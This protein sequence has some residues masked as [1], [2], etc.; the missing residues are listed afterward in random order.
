[1]SFLFYLFYLTKPD[2]VYLHR[3]GPRLAWFHAVTCPQILRAC[4]LTGSAVP[5][6]E[7]PTRYAFNKFS[8]YYEEVLANVSPHPN[9]E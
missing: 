4:C 3:C 1:M 5:R 7:I 6:L 9:F 8:I 2:F